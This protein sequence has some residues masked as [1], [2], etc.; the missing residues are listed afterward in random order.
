MSVFSW[1]DQIVLDE[2]DECL[3]GQWKNSHFA[4]LPGPDFEEVRDIF[5][6]E[7][8]AVWQALP[9]SERKI[10]WLAARTSLKYTCLSRLGLEPAQCT[11]NYHGDGR[12]ALA[13]A[14]KRVPLYISLTHALGWGG[15]VVGQGPVGIDLEFCRADDG[16][17]GKYIGSEDEFQKLAPLL[18]EKT[19]S[20]SPEALMFCLKESVLK[21]IGT[22]LTIPRFQVCLLNVS[23]LG[24]C[25]P[26]LKFRSKIQNEKRY[27]SGIA[28][29]TQAFV[30]AIARL[31]D[32]SGGQ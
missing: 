2:R 17:V 14:G 26:V 24:G 8:L 20:V 7:E 4:I 27:F 3:T 18:S 21:S 6:A 1:N 25:R 22:V 32:G 31:D 30:V 11:V 29:T 16:K 15:A 9:G 5:S 23:W 12:P 28:F 10:D 13:I 19:M